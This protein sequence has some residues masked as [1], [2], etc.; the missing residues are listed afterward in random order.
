MGT[1]LRTC[2]LANIGGVKMSKYIATFIIGVLLG[3]VCSGIVTLNI[4]DNRIDNMQLPLEE[5]QKWTESLGRELEGHHIQAKKITGKL[6]TL[7]GNA[8][9][10]VQTIRD[11][12]DAFN[13]A[14]R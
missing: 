14:G 9:E 13:K 2:C 4:L 10:L 12:I 7:D 8:E 5:L 1:V 11:E 6:I 3:V